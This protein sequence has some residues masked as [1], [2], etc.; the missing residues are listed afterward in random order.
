MLEYARYTLRAAQAKLITE[1]AFVLSRTKSGRS[2]SGPFA[3]F[4]G[5]PAQ[6]VDATQAMEQ[7][8]SWPFRTVMERI[9]ATARQ[10]QAN[11]EQCF[12]VACN[13]ENKFSSLLG[14]T[15]V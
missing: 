15:R 7:Y 9:A 8:R 14:I 13:R 5:V 12:G 2:P 1:F 6:V 3:A 10:M 11:L 4:L